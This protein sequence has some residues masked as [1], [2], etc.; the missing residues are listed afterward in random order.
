MIKAALVGAGDRGMNSYATYALNHPH[1]IQFVAVAEPNPE[2]RALFAEKHNIPPERQ[3]SSWEELMNEGKLCEAILICTQDKMHFE[4]V[5]AAIRLGYHIL[6]EKPMSPD[7]LETLLIAEEAEKHNVSITVCHVLRYSPYFEEIKALID[8]GAI[9]KVVSIQWTENVGYWHQAHSFVRGNWGN[10]KESSPMILQKCCHD[11]DL[12][13]WLAGSNCV[14]VSSEGSLSYFTRENAP[15]GSTERCTDG[16]AVEHECPYSAIKWYYN[17]IDEWP[18]NVPTVRPVLE[19]RLRAIQEG[20]YGRCVFRCDNDV[21]DHQTANLLFENGVTAAF[22]MVGLSLEN[23]RTFVIYGTKGEI[24]GDDSTNEFT[25]HEFSGKSYTVRPKSLG[26]GHGGADF[27]MMREFVKMV[28]G[29]AVSR[30]SAA[31]SAQSHLTTFAI[32]HSR[33]TGQTVVLKD[34]VEQ[35]KKQ[36]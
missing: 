3:Y 5:M 36:A 18:H 23:K 10:S 17:T 31:E 24:R 19:D 13:H 22:T 6:L 8:S 15:E 11:I 34:Y 4:P 21:V 27:G 1:E 25:V 14:R 30:T 29:Q 2:R 35:L 33:V 12:L 16:C 26:G 9:G 32:E 28:K 7:P 20:P